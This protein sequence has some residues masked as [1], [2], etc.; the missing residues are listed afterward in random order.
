MSDV[1]NKAR[2]AISEI[3]KQSNDSLNSISDIERD[4]IEKFECNYYKHATIKL[5]DIVKYAR[6]FGYDVTLNFTN[7]SNNKSYNVALDFIEFHKSI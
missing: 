2:Q 5:E 4:F 7:K 6:I 1:S 3:R